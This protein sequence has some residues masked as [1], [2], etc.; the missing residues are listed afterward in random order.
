MALIPL[1]HG[2]VA[3]V[4]DSDFE[5][6]RKGYKWSCDSDGYAVRHYYDENGKRKMEKMHRVIY[7]AKRG[8]LVDHRNR[9]TLDNQRHNL[10]SSTYSRNG[11]NRAKQSKP[12]LSTFK[13]I[14]FDPKREKW[15]AALRFNGKTIFIGRYSTEEEAASAYNKKATEMWN[16]H[17][18]LNTIIECGPDAGVLAENRR[19]GKSRV[20]RPV[21]S[22][23]FQRQAEDRP[24]P[25]SWSF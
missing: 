17:A 2:Q 8:E 25:G 16:E 24:G 1:S 4:D 7:G 14:W 19:S 23:C 15:R 12:A 21:E 20:V 10:R 3:I 18:R 13:G 9:N 5:W 22:Q 6:L 11:A